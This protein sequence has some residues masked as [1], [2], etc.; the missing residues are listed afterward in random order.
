[1][2]FLATHFQEFHCV[3]LCL[4]MPYIVQTLGAGLVSF[5]NTFVFWNVC[6]EV[7]CTKAFAFVGIYNSMHPIFLL[8]ITFLTIRDSEMA[9]N[10]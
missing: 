7:M 3:T 9:L 1:M 4:I 5:L 6:P 2:F 10:L 8:K